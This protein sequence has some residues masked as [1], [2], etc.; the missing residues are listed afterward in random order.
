[1]LLILCV[2]LQC[3][4]PDGFS[5]LGLEHI[6]TRHSRVLTAQL[7]YAPPGGRQPDH[8]WVGEFEGAEQVRRP[9]L[10]GTPSIHLR[11]TYVSC[12]YIALL[13]LLVTDRSDL[14]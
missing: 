14:R 4:G 1:L 10:E 11:T 13:D 12:L 9:G 2:L 3:L 7:G 6:H 8:D 5:H